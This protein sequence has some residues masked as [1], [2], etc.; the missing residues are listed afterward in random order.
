LPV[1]CEWV[2]PTATC[3]VETG[4]KLDAA[5]DAAKGTGDGGAVDAG[6]AALDV[7]AIGVLDDGAA[8]DTTGVDVDVLACLEPEVQAVA[9]VATTTRTPARKYVRYDICTGLLWVARIH[10]E[11]L[12]RPRSVVG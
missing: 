4:A 8:E 12:T 7:P 9:R 5:L 6:A 1:R 11:T 2:S 10:Q 3:A